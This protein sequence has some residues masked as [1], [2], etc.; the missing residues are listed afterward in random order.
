M[1]N[2]LPSWLCGK[3][4]QCISEALARH[5]CMCRETLDCAFFLLKF[6]IEK[7][8]KTLF[9]RFALKFFFSMAKNIEKENYP[10]MVTI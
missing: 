9:N 4:T 6:N 10:D 8:N 7:P 5:F 3:L 2:I 1:G